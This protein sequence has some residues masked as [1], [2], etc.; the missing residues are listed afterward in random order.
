MMRYFNIGKYK[1]PTELTKEH[2]KVK[3]QKEEY[4]SQF[5]RKD[6]EFDEWKEF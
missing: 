4:G 6:D 2:A 5:L 3:K 1:A